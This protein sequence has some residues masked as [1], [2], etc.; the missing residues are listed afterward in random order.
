MF[1][2]RMETPEV[3]RADARL[4]PS[5]STAAGSR[6]SAL[7][8]R[9]TEEEGTATW[10]TRT[11]GGPFLKRTFL[12]GG[13]SSSTAFELDFTFSTEPIGELSLEELMIRRTRGRRGLSLIGW[14]LALYVWVFWVDCWE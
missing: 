11:P 3:S 2:G 5:S 14:P 6:T 1:D 12:F 7:R 13:S 8:F 10:P 4:N 9:G